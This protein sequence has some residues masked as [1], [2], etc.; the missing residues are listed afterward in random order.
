MSAAPLLAFACLLPGAAHAQGDPAQQEVPLPCAEGWHASLVVDQEDVGIWTVEA[1]QVFEQYGAPELVGCDDRGRLVVLVSYGGKWTPLRVVED[2]RWLGGLAH[3]DVDPRV[4]GAELYAGGQSG[5]LYQVVAHASGRLDHR[6]IATFPGRELHTLVAG[7]L[8]PRAAGPELLAFASP[9]GVLRVRPTGEHGT[10]EAEEISASRGRVR[11]AVVLPRRDGEAVEIA[12]ASRGG[13]IELLTLGPGGPEWSTIHAAP[14]GMGRIALAPER[15][16]RPV[17]LYAT[18]DDGVVLRCER[19]GRD[20]WRIETIYLGPQ[21]MRG[22][23]AGRFDADP[24]A[25]TV[26]VFG[27]SGRVELLTRADAA[28]TVETI[29]T[30]RDKGHWLG[31]GELDGR[32]GTDE[33]FGAGY[34]GRIFL[35]AR[36]PGYA[37]PGIAIDPHA[38][39]RAPAE[40]A[41]TG[42]ETG[43]GQGLDVGRGDQGA[44]PHEAPAAG[45]R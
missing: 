7:D 43:D 28:W 11:D 10:F 5:S 22:I 26:A 12:T 4:P 30:D 39:E 27:Y 33:L 34:G 13:R 17:V 29:F 38:D 25:E 6:L 18:Q 15:A 42:A 20:A 36:P 21:G 41:G 16:G 23:V 31:A 24:E 37:R 45:G 40:P 8:D 14:M 3:G 19:E 9:G 1:Y 2:G 44:H 35:L 32:N